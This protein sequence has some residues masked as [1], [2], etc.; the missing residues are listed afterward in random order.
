[1]VLVV[2]FV[3]DV[4]FSFSCHNVVPLLLTAAAAAAAATTT[5]TTATTTTAVKPTDECAEHLERFL[6]LSQNYTT[7]HNESQQTN[8]RRTIICTNSS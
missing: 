5:T 2:V 1:M 7:C 8:H 6:E 4:P 3:T